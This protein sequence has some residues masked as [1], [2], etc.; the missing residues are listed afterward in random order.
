MISIEELRKSDPGLAD[1]SDA[2]IEKIRILL[3]SQAQL[4]LKYFVKHKMGKGIPLD[5][6]EVK[7]RDS[8]T[9]I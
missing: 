1:K 2:E 6:T 3:Y 8:N 5:S 9:G 4:A 7:R